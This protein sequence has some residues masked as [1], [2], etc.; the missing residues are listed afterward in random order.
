MA[1]ID[2]LEVM[3][4]RQ[5]NGDRVHKAL[6]AKAMLKRRPPP[7]LDGAPRGKRLAQVWGEIPHEP[8][9]TIV[10]AVLQGR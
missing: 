9:T 3:I 1:R 7:G 5:Q 8:H 6:A 10:L 2:R 4:D